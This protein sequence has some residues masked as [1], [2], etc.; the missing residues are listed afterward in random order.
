MERRTDPVHAAGETRS[1]S[2]LLA[3]EEWGAD[4]LVGCK[5]AES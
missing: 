5:A 4:G 1:V 2:A 3:A